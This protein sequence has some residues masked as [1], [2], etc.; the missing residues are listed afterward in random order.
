M[1]VTLAAIAK[2]TIYAHSQE[3]IHWYLCKVINLHADPLIILSFP[4]GAFLPASIVQLAYTHS[5]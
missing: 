3:I 1:D 5:V 2:I 4:Q